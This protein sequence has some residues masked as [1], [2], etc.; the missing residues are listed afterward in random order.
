MPGRETVYDSIGVGY[1]TT[2]RTDPRLAAIIYRALGDAA[3]VVNVGAGTGSYE[4]AD[5]RVLAV[6][7]SEVMIGQRP[8]GSA[9]AVAGSAEALPLDDASVDAAMASLTLHHWSDWRRGVAEMCRVARQRVVLFTWDPAGEGFWLT[10]EYLPWLAAWDATRFPTLPEIERALPGPTTVEA[11]PIPRDCI[12]GLL[13][14][15][16]ARPEAYLDP[17][18]Q[19]GFSM[20][21]LA[22]DPDRLIASLEVLAADLEGGAWH[23]RHQGLLSRQTLD[24]GYRVITATLGAFPPEGSSA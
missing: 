1:T 23:V 11:V 21:A 22:P 13:A 19:R 14:A 15:F 7:P 24:A 6:E 16:W 2:R 20:F 12:D 3:S 8:R 4:P 9:P 18:V 17:V 5:R 10:R